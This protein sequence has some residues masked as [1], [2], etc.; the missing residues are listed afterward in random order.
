[1]NESKLTKEEKE[2]PQRWK[3]QLGVSLLSPTQIT[4]VIYL[5]RLKLQRPETEHCT[6]DYTSYLRGVNSE[7]TLELPFVDPDRPCHENV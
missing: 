4:L 2:E 3:D 7:L 6:R 5:R 1:M